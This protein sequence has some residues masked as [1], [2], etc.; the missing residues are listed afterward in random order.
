MKLPRRF[1]WPLMW[2]VLALAPLGLLAFT[3]AES[4]AVPQAP[5]PGQIVLEGLIEPSEEVE[6]AMASEGVLA[7]VLVER[8]DKVARGAVVARL[9]SRAEEMALA[10]AVYRAERKEGLH[11]AEARVE[12]AQAA[13]NRQD[14]LYRDG[15]VSKESWEESQTAQY[16]AQQSLLAALED[17]RLA[18]IDAKRLGEQLDRRELVSPFAGV[19]VKRYLDPGEL[20]SRTGQSTVI[21]LACLDPLE[22]R[23]IAPLGLWG[24]VA[25]DDVVPV[26]PQLPV[27]GAWR[28][29]VVAID[30]VIDAASGTFEVLLELE[31]GDQIL[32]AGI[33]CTV[34]FP[35]H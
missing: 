5:A 19:V 9:E 13:A 17:D 27:E 8:G 20:V 12:Y 34:E 21:S 11:Q 24:Q 28:G 14:R 32:P 15:L 22:V 35:R 10:A 2:L 1:R 6:L 30:R 16:L 3:A 31:N 18:E 25:V 7:T 29:R 26:V 4:E 23:V 33:H